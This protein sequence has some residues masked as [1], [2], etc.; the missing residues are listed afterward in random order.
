[1]NKKVLKIHRGSTMEDKIRSYYRSLHWFDNVR[2]E[3]GVNRCFY[4]GLDCSLYL[5]LKPT[6]LG[7]Y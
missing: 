5:I 6:R 7:L 3:G 2:N 1:M 4:S